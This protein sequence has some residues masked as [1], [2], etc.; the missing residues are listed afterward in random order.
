ME[1]DTISLHEFRKQLAAPPFSE[2]TSVG[3]SLEDLRN[4]TDAVNLPGQERLVLVQNHL[5][6]LVSYIEK[7]EGFSLF[8]GER[9][10]AGLKPG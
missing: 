5:V 3:E 1:F 9:K 2:T 7:R 8:Q 10:K 4:A 6:D